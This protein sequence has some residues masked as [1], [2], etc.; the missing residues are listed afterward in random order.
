MLDKRN[1]SKAIA[2]LGF[3][4]LLGVASASLTHAQDVVWSSIGSA[5][6]I[7]T[8]SKTIAK[9]QRASLSMSGSGTLVARYP[10]GPNAE[11]AAGG[12]FHLLGNLVDM[13]ASGSISISLIEVAISDQDGKVAGT[14][15]TVLTYASDDE[16]PGVLENGCVSSTKAL[17]F[18]HNVYY[19]QAVLSTS[20]PSAP[21]MLRAMQIGLGDCPQ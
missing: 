10:V 12:P 18:A 17:D 14:T 8:A 3:A 13:G 20:T 4:S 11:L 9:T 5:G 19:V 16:N 2:V 6:Q 1:K 7:D 21:P 15:A